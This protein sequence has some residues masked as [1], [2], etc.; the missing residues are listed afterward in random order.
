[1]RHH[2]HHYQLQQQQQQ[3]QQQHQIMSGHLGGVPSHIQRPFENSMPQ[4]SRNPHHHQMMSGHHGVIPSHIQ[5]PHQPIPT[6][7]LEN[8]TPQ[9]SRNPSRNSS[10]MNLSRL[11]FDSLE[12]E[13]LPMFPNIMDPNQGVL[14]GP[15]ELDR[16]ARISSG[17]SPVLSTSSISD[18][19]G[20]LI[21]SGSSPAQSTSSINDSGGQLSGNGNSSLDSLATRPS[22]LAIDVD[23]QLPAD[24]A[25]AQGLLPQAITTMNQHHS[26]VQQPPAS[27]PYEKPIYSYPRPNG[28]PWMP[29]LPNLPLPSPPKKKL[30][31]TLQ[32]DGPGLVRRHSF[33]AG[34]LSCHSPPSSRK[35][36]STFDSSVYASSAA[37]GLMP[38]G[39][40]IDTFLENFLNSE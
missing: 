33:D 17:A 11:E 4:V 6:S 12:L 28:F 14:F 5:R 34:A 24:I 39:I 20:Q 18:S 16:S 19:M 3:Q 15:N 22:H 26:L 7:P 32:Q 13:P 23:E 8:S 38:P 9:L 40:T 36:S 1:M 37:R 35:G 30:M 2:H 10:V 21:S 25:V 27:V 29:P 31:A